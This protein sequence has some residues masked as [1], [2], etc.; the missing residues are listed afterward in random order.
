MISVNEAVR[1]LGYKGNTP[2]ERTMNLI[3][4]CI[5]EIERVSEPKS[6]YRQ[7]DLKITEDNYVQ[8]A[9]LSMHS[10]NLAK[11][12]KGCTKIFFMAAT[13][14]NGP[15]RLM[16]QYTRLSISKAAILQAVGAAA[17]EDYCNSIQKK[18]EQEAALSKLYIRPRFSPGYGDL[19]LNHQA[20][21]LRVLNA[22]KTV[23]I[24][25]SEGGVMIPEKSVTAM[26]GVS[27][28]NSRCHI[29]G[30][31]SCNNINCPF[32]RES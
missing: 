21:F 16:N 28:I 29:E 31:E 5:D 13:L 11:N 8:A 32:R 20:D 4:T 2:D 30:C 9:G 10:S 26:M 14:G 7:F 1:Y 17:I 18:I 24:I 23:G 22:D 6:I 12:L 15:D 19:S 25:L 27:S 3:Y